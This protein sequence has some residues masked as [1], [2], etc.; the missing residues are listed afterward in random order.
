MALGHW[1]LTPSARTAREA[2]GLSLEAVAAELRI[3]I[4]ILAA[5]EREDH[6]ALPERVYL[7]G[8]LRTYAR[9]LGLDPATVAAGW[10]GEPPAQQALPRAQEWPQ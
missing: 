7:L 8:L 3:R 6:T 9:F 4:V 5:M 10:A 1:H 2:R